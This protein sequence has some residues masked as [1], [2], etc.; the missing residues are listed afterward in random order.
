[1]SERWLPMAKKLPLRVYRD[2]D[3]VYTIAACTATGA[4]D[5]LIGELGLDPSAAGPLHGFKEVPPDEIIKIRLVDELSTGQRA[6]LEVPARARV[7]AEATA[8]DWAKA[9][10]LGVLCSTEW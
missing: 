6:D 2:G 1:M 8:A 7:Y 5:W 4:R 3:S 10:G 9:N